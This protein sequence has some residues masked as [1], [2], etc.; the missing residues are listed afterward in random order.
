MSFE[1]KAVWQIWGGDSHLAEHHLVPQVYHGLVYELKDQAKRYRWDVVIDE[2]YVKGGNKISQEWTDRYIKMIQING[3]KPMSYVIC[4]GSNN[5]RNNPS[6]AEHR[7]VLEQTYQV[8][9]QV[10]VT[11]CA[12]LCVI[13]PIP[14]GEGRSDARI[15]KLNRDLRKV[16][17]I[18][19]DNRLDFKKEDWGL[20]TTDYGESNKVKYVPFTDH[21][22]PHLN[23]PCKARF[24]EMFFKRDKIHLNRMGARRM[25]EE[26][27]KAQ[28]N[29]SNRIY[30]FGEHQ[31]S[32]TKRLRDAYPGQT[33]EDMDQDIE[34]KVDEYLKFMRAECEKVE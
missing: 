11:R 29:F 12:T 25:A 7:K 33:V 4:I 18:R 20:K 28:L 19:I 8:I 17:R 2:E 32:T 27:L 5:V 34:R 1:A 9:R 31:V 14:D 26:I 3:G 15:E 24:T 22:L 6:E 16:C 21:V 13:S 30:G 23:N 10:E